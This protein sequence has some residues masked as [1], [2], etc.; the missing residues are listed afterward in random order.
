MK[1]NGILVPSSSEFFKFNTELNFIDD[2]KIPAKFLPRLFHHGSF[3]L[4]TSI[5][6]VSTAKFHA[7]KQGPANIVCWVHMFYR[8]VFDIKGNK[9]IRDSKCSCLVVMLINKKAVF[10]VLSHLLIMVQSMSRWMMS[11]R[12]I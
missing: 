7:F 9:R 10:F 2:F 12:L 8:E 4:F 1:P 5:K 6:F 11:M 3:G